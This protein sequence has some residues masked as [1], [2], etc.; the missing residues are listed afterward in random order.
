MNGRERSENKMGVMPVNRLLLTMSAPMMA[1]MLVQAMYNVVDSVFVARLGEDALTAVSLAFPVQNMIIGVGVGTGVGVNA[2]LSR[3]LGEKNFSMVSGTA[4]NGVFLAW[5]SA[6]AFTLF[7]AVGVRAYFLTQTDSPTIA[8]YGC[9]Y[10]SIISLFSFGVFNQIMLERLLTSTG[11]TTLTMAAQMVGALIN[12]VLDPIMIFGLLGCPRLEVAGAA[13]ATVTGQFISAAVALFFNLR[14]NGEVVLSPRGFRP[15]LR[16]IG[17]IYS[18]GLPSILMSSLGSVSVYC[19]NGLLMSFTATATAVFGVY[20]KLQSFIFMP[21]F[22]LNNGLVPIIAYNHG[23]GK[24]DRVRLAVNLGMAYATGVMAIGAAAFNLF[25]RELLLMF[26]AGAE[27]LNIGVPALRII[28]FHYVFAGVCIV[29][30]SVFQALGR[31]MASL[32]VAASRQ[33]L[34]LLPVAWLLSLAGE[35]SLV[36]WSFPITEAATL[37]LNL[38]MWRGLRRTIIDAKGAVHNG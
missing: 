33:L 29:F 2:F 35:L 16:T 15:S 1:A 7:G 10:L 26:G 37:A 17:R 13:I 32:I 19:F 38:L 23:A 12:V 6:A 20:F 14:Y 31:G 24:Y 36:W 3:S 34:L 25:P 5:L 18:V 21:V 30:L 9:D 27:M 8:A 11:K 28:G 22:G 4:M